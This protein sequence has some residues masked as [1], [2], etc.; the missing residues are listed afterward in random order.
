MSP[1]SENQ[2]TLSL[3]L[4]VGQVVLYTF[5]VLAILMTASELLA[6]N[7]AVETVL[8]PPAVNGDNE[9]GGKLLGLDRLAAQSGRIGCITL[10]SSMA[11][12]GIDPQAISA[13]YE[14]RLNKPFPCFNFAI[15]GSDAAAAGRLA[16]ALVREYRPR[17]VIYGTSYRDYIDDQNELDIPWTR[18]YTGAPTLEGWFEARSYAYRYALTYRNLM[19]TGNFHAWGAGVEL[20]AYGQWLQTAAMPSDVVQLDAENKYAQW[21]ADFHILPSTVIGLDQLLALN[22]ADVQIILVEMPLPDGV[23]ASVPH[24]EQTRQTF[25]DMVGQRA[26]ARH[27]PFWLTQ[28]IFN[29][30]AGGWYNPFHMND[31][32]SM[33]FGRWLGERL[34]DAVQSGQLADLTP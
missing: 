10:G 18:Y 34:A 26:A 14:A 6:R 12:T 32:G 29:P 7:P 21:S 5:A 30:P 2:R 20:T 27:V 1:P 22:S 15:I 8:P 17:V 13:A 23:I 28:G 25:V 19:R 24:G 9:I 31:K 3:T 4:P 33:A 11:D 16:T